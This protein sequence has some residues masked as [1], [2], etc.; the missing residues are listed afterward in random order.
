MN[1]PTQS[2][3]QFLPALTGVRFFAALHIFLFHIAAMSD[4]G[5]MRFPLLDA[6]PAWLLRL[7]RHGYCSTGLFFLLS[8]FI[9]EYLF[10]EPDGRFA[11]SRR[12]FWFDRWGRV[13]P[14]HLLALVITAPLAFPF[15]RSM[16]PAEVCGSLILSGT[17]TQAWVPAWA[18]TWNA[19]TWALSA[20]AFFYFLFPWIASAISRLNH[21][22]LWVLL[23]LLW[24]LG[25]APSVLY[26]ILEPDGVE[27]SLAAGDNRLFW[28]NLLKFN[29]ALWIPTFSSGA[30][31]ARLFGMQRNC[32]TWRDP[33]PN[34]SLS[35]GDLAAIA[36]L[37]FATAPPILPYVIERHGILTPLYLVLIYDLA[38]GRGCLARVLAWKPL[39]TLGN[40]S[41]GIFALQVPVFL[42][43]V[44]GY[45]YSQGQLRTDVDATSPLVIPNTPLLAGLIAVI[46]ASLISHRWYARPISQWLRRRVTATRSATDMIREAT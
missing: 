24:G 7:I 17:L 10:V 41:F 35:W 21:G 2:N 36:A 13:Y 31:L 26:L 4:S 33:R 18:L 5:L 40:A 28:M 6:A 9:L 25:L 16:G 8:G 45:L 20:V 43:V 44:V 15:V 3:S 22:R 29:P 39:V 11:G 38:Q 27:S 19:P 34:A 12:R 46:M 37:A 42:G 1:S 14:L 30:V 32:S 23:G